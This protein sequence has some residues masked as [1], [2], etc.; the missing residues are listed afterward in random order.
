[1]SS[2]SSPTSSLTLIPGDVSSDELSEQVK[3]LAKRAQGVASEKGYHFDSLY[4][5][6]ENQS[7][8]VKTVRNQVE[9]L[10]QLLE[11]Q[12]S[13]LDRNMNQ[14]VVKTWFEAQ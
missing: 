7:T 12:K 10:K 8:D 5:I 6:A 4:E 1:M 11:L 13:M 2:T 14:P 9:E 3:A